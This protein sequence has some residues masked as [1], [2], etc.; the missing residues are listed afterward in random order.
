LMT[1]V[2]VSSLSVQAQQPY[3]KH[4]QGLH[5]AWQ[6]QEHCCPD[7]WPLLVTSGSEGSSRNPTGSVVQDLVKQ[8]GA[9]MDPDRWNKILAV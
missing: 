5:T 7:T 3:A 6:Q 1:N 2:N 9:A 4:R 8:P